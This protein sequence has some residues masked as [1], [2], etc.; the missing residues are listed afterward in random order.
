[1]NDR[2]K[3]LRALSLEAKPSISVERAR[4]ITDF[5]RTPLAGQ[6]SIPVQRALAFKHL[7]E[8]KSI[9]INEGE[10]IV[11]ERGTAPKATPTY[12]EVC[13]HSVQDLEIL[14][15]RPKTSFS[16]D[17]ETR[18]I[19]AESVIP[20]W[21][22][23][24]IR[25]K[26][27]N[28]VYDDWKAAYEAGVFTEFM[29]QRAPGHTVLDDKI[30]RKGM[31]D[32]KKDIQHSLAMID[33][34]ND[35]KALDKREELKAM[36]IVVDAIIVFANRH[37]QKLKAL[38]A[39]GKNLERIAELEQMADI[40]MRVPANAPKTFWEALQYYWFVHLGVIT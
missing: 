5:Y 15:S 6:V 22:G 35:P 23:K 16:V 4:L 26:I 18:K 17:D 36:E 13:L 19:Y 14:D 9:C 32:F 11:G 27:F 2:I 25:D 21:Q 38:I 10:L 20:F 33:F 39:K 1:M 31:L 34:Y 37:A 30:Y 12:P 8:N 7:M 24:S 29:E 40:C 28:E 3:K